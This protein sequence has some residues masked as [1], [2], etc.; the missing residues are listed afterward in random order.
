M[1]N[2]MHPSEQHPRQ[3]PEVA[4]KWEMIDAEF[5]NAATHVAL[6]PTNKIFMYGGSSLDLD[7]FNNPTLP[8]AEILDLNTD[9]WQTYPV[10]C[11]ALNGDLWCG[12]HTFLPDGKLLFVGGTSYYPP[13]PD[14]LY[15]GLNEAYL[16]DPFMETWE[17]LDDMQ[18]G[19]WYPTLIRCADDSILT[20]SGLEYRH[21]DEEPQT[22]AIRVLWE[23]ITNI[24]KR[25]VRTHEIYFPE[26]KK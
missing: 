8:R 16:F 6:L 23:L 13:Q 3:S 26:T 14:P 19:R 7:E 5:T 11:D 17:R 4:G 10:N 25:I 24:K 15:G 21:P 2:G 18:A 1:P 12:G 22:N 9:P 20:I